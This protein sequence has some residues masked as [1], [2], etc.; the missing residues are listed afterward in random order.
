M[1][2]LVS[3]LLAV[4]NGEKYLQKQIESIL[5]QSFKEFK[6]IIR[7]DGSTDK[8]VEIINN[9]CIWQFYRKRKV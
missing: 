5:A 3:I 2:I 9:Y 8:S 7:D 4:Y 1:W 6:I